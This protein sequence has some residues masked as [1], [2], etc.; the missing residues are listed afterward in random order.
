MKVLKNIARSMFLLFMLCS[1]I[2]NDT[3]AQTSE[4][5]VLKKLELYS[6][7]NPTNLLFVHTDKTVYTNNETI[8][9]SAYLLK[10]ES[11]DL[12]KHTILSVAIVR[13]D[14][15]EV[16][17][18]AK[19]IMKTGLSFGSL[20][21]PDSIPPGNY[22][23]IASTNVWDKEARPLCV[24]SQPLSIKSIT[25]QDFNANLS[26]LDTMINNGVVRVKLSVIPKTFNPRL[27][28]TVE[29]KVNQGISQSATL[30]ENNYIISIPAIQLRQAQPVLL[31]TIKYNNTIQYL[32]I[33]LP[34][35]NL[36]ETSTETLNIRFF[37]EGGNLVDGLE[38]TIA[39]ESK[40]TND[41]PIVLNG[42]L[43]KNDIPVDTISTN[44]YG[45]GTFRLKPDKNSNYRVKI[46]ANNSLEQ[47]T[48]Y[49]LPQ[50]LENG[51]V[52]HVAEAVLNDTLRLNLFSSQLTKV[53]VFIHNYH[54][55][56]ASFETEITP[57][58]TKKSVVMPIIP[59]G[60]ATITVL[61]MEGRPLAER[62]LFAH[63]DQRT[64]IS[65][66]PDKAI[67]NKKD[68]V[69]ISIRLVDKKAMAVVGIVSV[70]AV[71]D[72]RIEG[73]KQQDIE[74]Y[75]YLNYDLGRLPRDPQGGGLSNKS[76]IEN[77]LLVK[78]W[79][80]Y[81]WQS[82]NTISSTV[83]ERQIQ[84]PTFLGIVQYNKRQLKKAA[85]FTIFRDSSIDVVAT[86][87][88]GLFILDPGKLVT[89]EGR[90]V[91]AIVNEKVRDGYTINVEDPF[92][93]LNRE[94]ASRVEVPTR[95][96]TKN[97]SSTDLQV[98]GL[99]RVIALQTVTITADKGNDLLYGAKKIQGPNLCGD[100]VCRFGNLNCVNHPNEPGNVPAIPGNTYNLKFYSGCIIEGKPIETVFNLAGIYFAREFYGVNGDSMGLKEQQYYSTLFWKP[101]MLPDKNG[102]I[103]LSFMTGDITGK[104]KIIIQG[105]G[106]KD[107][108]FGEGSLLVK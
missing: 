33:R 103:K 3:T 17:L 95:G 64:T 68:S 1:L 40:T 39:W 76:Y 42:I 60:I 23:L 102:E 13:E 22:Q 94:L 35:A 58:G 85:E 10:S 47:D 30:S 90:K 36:P 32:N 101:G 14:N 86:E 4:D 67:Y 105:V 49:K 43:Y 100:Y 44:S 52:I 6:K 19:Y 16:S 25:E 54:E 87:P 29:Y 80:R 55:A 2:K 108:I 48:S 11:I 28:A 82:L 84:S 98:S 9:F 7:A 99:E 57:S 50:I 53:R 77:I 59:K 24:F 15:R 26:L 74:S 46:A 107:M 71:Q 51:I 37:P 83:A 61:D 65:I 12:S 18:Q 56:F 81:T 97:V 78:G 91:F 92:I 73:I 104:F 45:I 5:A 72:N 66:T 93:P 8:W 27:K 34:G 38:S 88:N 89:K 96:I 63:Y 69:N 41:I 62:L 21:L 75:N 106:E 20:N 70:A 79:R 31:T